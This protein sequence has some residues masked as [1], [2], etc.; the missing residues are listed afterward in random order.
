MLLMYKD[1]PFVGRAGRGP[2]V[3]CEVH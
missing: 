3:T 2:F 1:F